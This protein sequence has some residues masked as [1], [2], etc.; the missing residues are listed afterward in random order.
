M[1]RWTGCPLGCLGWHDHP[2]IR[3][4]ARCNYCTSMDVAARESL[5]TC[6]DV[7]PMRQVA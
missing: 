4:V 5:E 6:W 1:P 7:C 2:P 3:F